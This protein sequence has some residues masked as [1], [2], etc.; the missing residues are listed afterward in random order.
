MTCFCLCAS[1]GLLI[2][3]VAATRT[4]GRLLN[5]RLIREPADVTDRLVVTRLGRL[6]DASRATV[7]PFPVA[8][9]GFGASFESSLPGTIISS[10]QMMI[11]RECVNK[12]GTQP[13]SLRG[14]IGSS[15]D[16]HSMHFASRATDTRAVNGDESVAS[17]VM[18]RDLAGM[19][20]I[21]VVGVGAASHAVEGRAQSKSENEA[22]LR[23]VYD[24]GSSDFWIASDLC[25]RGPC[26][27]RLRRRFNHS[28]SASFHSPAEPLSIHTAYGSGALYGQLGIDDVRVG[29][30]VVRQQS[31]GL[32]TEEEGPTFEQL[33][34]DGIVGL[35][36]A[37]LAQADTVPLV[38][39]MISQGALPRREFAFYLHRDPSLGGAI[40]WGGTDSRLYDGEL[41]W[42]PVVSE[43]YWTLDLISFA[44]GKRN[45]RTPAK[46]V[47]DSGTTFFS[48]PS[49][50]SDLI[51]DEARWATCTTTEH[52]P[53]LIF[54][55]RDTDGAPRQ[56]SVRPEEYMVRNSILGGCIPAVVPGDSFSNAVDMII[57]GEVFMR[58]HFTVFSRGTH[59]DPSPRVGI[60]RAKHDGGVDNFF[61]E[62]AE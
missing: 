10:R 25:S 57:I 24:T 40:L 2:A 61:D 44:I 7:A 9:L 4:R 31:I 27:Q 17:T 29:S 59:A 20:Y 16:H 62:M 56:L 13:F 34:F 39:T 49:R 37:S 52:L 1:L 18:L 45:V 26:T 53:P 8:P 30:L 48:V 23:V 50:I 35:G 55:I 3:G 36:F 51:H 28:M 41:S 33:D 11:L 22:E 54:V 32:I 38:D 46:L 21:G 12:A 60:A 19:E 42:F 43:T 14:T 15:V 6:D 47:V 5:E 58:H